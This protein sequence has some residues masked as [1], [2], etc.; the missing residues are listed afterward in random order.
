ME[1]KLIA[2]V[3]KFRPEHLGGEGALKGYSA[4]TGASTISFNPEKYDEG[5][6]EK[7]SSTYVGWKPD[8]VETGAKRTPRPTRLFAPIYNGLGAALGLALTLEGLRKLLGEFWLVGN[9][10][11]FALIGVFPFLFCVSLVRSS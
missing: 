7:R 3:W 9:P 4:S 6:E 10:V 8:D 2:L 1:E 11:R 5:D